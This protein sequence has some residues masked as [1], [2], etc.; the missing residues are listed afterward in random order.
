MSARQYQQI[1]NGC[2]FGREEKRSSMAPPTRYPNAE[3]RRAAVK[4][5]LAQHGKLTMTQRRALAKQFQCTPGIIGYDI[6]RLKQQQSQEERTKRQPTVMQIESLV[7]YADER[8]VAV[9][10]ALGRLEVMTSNQIKQLLFPDVQ[11]EAMRS[12][13]SWLL[14]NNYI[15]R[16]TTS[17]RA[18]AP[19]EAGHSRRQPPPKAPYIYGLT[20]EGKA[21]LEVMEAEVNDA[22]YAL[23]KSRDRRAPEIP[24][25]QL[26]HDLLAS[27]WCTSV[28]DAA[29]RCSLLVDIRCH[30]EYV[31]A[32]DER[33]KE[34]QRFDAYLALRFQ[35]K[36]R[37]QTMPGWWIPWHDGE[38]DSAGDVTV[39]FAL[40]VDRGT[41]KLA[42]LLGKALT[43]RQLTASKHYQQTLGGP[44]TPVILAPPG[45][46][47][48]Q[49]A[50][51]WQEGWPKGVGVISTPAKANHAD[52][53][54]LWGQ[55]LTLTDSPAKPTTL[56]GNLVPTIDAW[57]Q[58]VRHWLPGDVEG[59][60]H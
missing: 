9:L 18:V 2:G 32:Y 37:P 49:I 56:L 23:L 48:A 55:Y 35:R 20:H 10:R 54:A 42:I 50:R 5:Q 4:A 8:D 53:G 6:A 41:E 30:V 45:R 12:R 44:V 25:H 47:A 24:Q 21:Q 22:A 58:L 52:Y 7:S 16:T 60:T 3:A 31:S 39:R 19:P 46:R 11:R 15:W 27:G 43:Y 14:E 29:R 13:L 26:T 36:P 57:E 34:I 38:A 28:I 59:A 33:N 1:R 51:E 40:E 17:M